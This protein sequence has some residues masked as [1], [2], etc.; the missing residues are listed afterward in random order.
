LSASQRQSTSTDGKSSAKQKATGPTANWLQYETP[1]KKYSI[2]LADGWK[3][4]HCNG[5]SLLFTYDHAVVS[6]KPGKTAVV[7]N[8]DCGSDGGGDGLFIS[9][10]DPTTYQTT[11]DP[12]VRTF[13]TDTG[14]TVKEYSR[15]E[16]TNA[17]GLG[18][19]DKGGT[20]Y[21]Y[22]VSKTPTKAVSVSYGVNP[23]Q[24]ND[25]DTVEQA[26]KTIVVN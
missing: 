19:L 24:S 9:F 18:A 21:T 3:L 14:D 11:T 8:M 6:P 5:S 2:R 20:Y 15:I 1:D 10:Y 22:V 23:G 7:T 12:L 4:D 16:A 13:K 26:I 25:H 17:D